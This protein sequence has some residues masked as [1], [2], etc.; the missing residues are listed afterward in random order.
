MIEKHVSIER[1]CGILS[2]VA[3]CQPRCVILINQESQQDKFSLEYNGTLTLDTQLAKWNNIQQIYG[4][5]S[6]GNYSYRCHFKTRTKVGDQKA[7]GSNMLKYFDGVAR[8]YNIPLTIL[9]N[10]PH[11]Y[12]ATATAIRSKQRKTGFVS[13]IPICATMILSPTQTWAVTFSIFV[14]THLLER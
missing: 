5:G 14:P 7:D 6:N 12:T 2:M 8:P 1:S 3:A 11:G 9:L 10:F 4:M 13:P